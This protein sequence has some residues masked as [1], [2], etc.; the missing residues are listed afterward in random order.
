MNHEVEVQL[1]PAAPGQPVPHTHI[2]LPESMSLHD[3]VH[4]RSDAGD[5]TIVFLGDDSPFLDANNNAVTLITSAAPPLPLQKRGQFTCRCFITL[6]TGIT[7]GWVIGDNP[8]QGGG[9]HVVN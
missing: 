5:V 2:A 6:P 3:T 9:I 4:Y 8:P 1:L 7:V